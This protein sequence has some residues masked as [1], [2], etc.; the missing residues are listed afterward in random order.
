MPRPSGSLARLFVGSGR[1]GLLHPAPD[2]GPDC[3]CQEHCGQWPQQWADC[4]NLR[5]LVCKQ[6]TD[7]NECTL[8]GRGVPRHVC[9][10]T[11]LVSAHLWA[12]VLWAMGA[13]LPIHMALLADVAVWGRLLWLADKHLPSERNLTLGKSMV[14]KYTEI[15]I[16]PQGAF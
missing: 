9:P 14:P 8:A 10:V 1:A 5:V 2:L 16:P 3:L 11:R 6:R 15:D 7:M 12:E 4:S 13:G